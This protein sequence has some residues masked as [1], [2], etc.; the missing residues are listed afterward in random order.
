MADRQSALVFP[1]LSEILH[2]FMDAKAEALCGEKNAGTA[3]TLRVF[4]KVSDTE[5]C[6]RCVAALLNID[7]DTL[8]IARNRWG[9]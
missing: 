4:E 7:S 3:S 1:T 9:L 2:V 5:R 6:T 8:E